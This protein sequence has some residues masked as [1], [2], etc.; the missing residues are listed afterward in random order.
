MHPAMAVATA[1]APSLVRPAAPPQHPTAVCR[2]CQ[3]ALVMAQG[4]WWCPTHACA[5]RQL[6][7]ATYRQDDTGAV[8]EYLYVPAPA[9][10]E[11]HD[12]VYNRSLRRVLC[13]GAAGP[14]KSRMIREAHYLLAQQVPGYHGLLL[15]RTHKDLEQ[16]HLR[17]MPFEVEQRGGAYRAGPPAV[18]TF[19]HSNAPSSVIRCGHMESEQDVQNYLS[20]EYDCI[21]PDELV[22][23]PR[24]TMLELFTRARTTNPAMLALRGV[25]EQD[26]DGA[27]VL[28]ASNPGGRGGAW[29]KDFFIDK[30]PDLEEFPNYHPEYWAFF[31][32]HLRDNPYVKVGGYTE[33]LGELRDA[34]KRQL[35]DGD[36]TVFE[37]QFF[38][39]WQ[40]A[41]HVR[42]LGPIA[43]ECPRFLSM[44]WGHNAPGVVLWWVV[45]PDGH[46]H[47][48]DEFKFNGDVGTKL[49][50]KDVA[51]VI[52]DRCRDLGLQRVPTTWLD[53]ACWQHTGQIGE[54]I[55]DTFIR[56]RIPVAKA[57]NERINGWNRCHELLRAAP[58]GIPWLTVAPRCTYLR[59]T[60]PMQ[61]QSKLN[62]DDMNTTGDDHGCDAWRY[63]SVSGARPLG[64]KHY[65][66]SE[67]FTAR[68][69]REQSQP[70]GTR[71]GS[72]SC[73]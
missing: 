46:Y 52:R 59:R 27:L 69:W 1:G 61:L 17:F 73:R 36:W 55:A 21:S 11:W 5:L 24:D 32:A 35:L 37:G 12:A 58:D 66:R 22:T 71:L 23:F 4:C 13:G 48:D 56:W 42:D 51:A 7:Y 53:P 34:R 31:P 45:L 68:W 9:Q 49:T 39:E 44:D 30:T 19:L 54:S 28:S 57:N 67:Q 40:E 64:A 70:Q 6:K 62:P 63:G 47:I 65:T 50:V 60:I 8:L 33:S 3:R 29:V 25:P 41:K 43:M 72:E 26:Y 10:V 2:W 14:G 18:V 15:R 16:S 38:D 20:A